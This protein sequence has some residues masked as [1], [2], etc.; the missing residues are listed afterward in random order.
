V[1]TTLDELLALDLL[2]LREHTELAGDVLDPSVHRSRVE[3]SMQ[4]S[5]LCAVRR[6]GRLA[7]YAM[8]QPGTDGGWFVTGFNVHPSAR[9]ASVMR[10]L[11][12]AVAD[13]IERFGIDS[14]CSHV[15]KT[16]DRSIRFHRRLGFRVARENDKGIEFRA[17]RDELASAVTRVLGRR[18]LQCREP[19][20]P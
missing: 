18:P 7:G 6:D 4:V 1:N 19:T 12:A 13:R 17:T 3:R 8:F 5:Q 15:Y 14:L 9:N 20:L 2:T 10:E 11:I 16:N